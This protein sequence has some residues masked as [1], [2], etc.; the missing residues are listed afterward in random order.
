LSYFN[1]MFPKIA[2]LSAILLIIYIGSVFKGLWLIITFLQTRNYFFLS[3]NDKTLATVKHI[4]PTF[5]TNPIGSL[6]L[7][8]YSLN[9]YC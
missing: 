6:N 5:L 4:I 1:I 7:S 2:D 3:F 8:I 9:V